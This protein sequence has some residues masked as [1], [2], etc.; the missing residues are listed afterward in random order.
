MINKSVDVFF[1][2]IIPPRGDNSTK[3]GNPAKLFLIISVNLATFKITIGGIRDLKYTLT[4]QT[5]ELPQLQHLIIVSQRGIN[6]KSSKKQIAFFSISK[7]DIH[8]KILKLMS[9]EYIFQLKKK[10]N[11]TNSSSLIT[12]SQ[13]TM[14]DS[15]PK[16]LKI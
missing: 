12:I 16:F 13:Q 9:K 3:Y 4:Q 7:I 11:Q 5:I 15:V 1:K 6:F 14:G 10:K 8:D 2:S